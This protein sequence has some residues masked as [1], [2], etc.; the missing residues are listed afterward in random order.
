MQSV[1]GFALLG[2]IDVLS[3]TARVKIG[4]DA[5]WERINA[6]IKVRKKKN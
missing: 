2:A 6:L 4:H 5:P 1:S 3:E